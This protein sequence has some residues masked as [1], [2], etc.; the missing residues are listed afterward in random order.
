M[1][2]YLFKKDTIL[3][4]IMVFLLMGLLSL[5]PFNTH[6]LDPIKLALQDFDYNDMAYSQ[7]NKNS[8]CQ[9]RQNKGQLRN[10]KS[11]TSGLKNEMEKQVNI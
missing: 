8:H 4:T 2:K 1:F 9:L 11:V 10:K 7:F 3:A 6:V 5:I